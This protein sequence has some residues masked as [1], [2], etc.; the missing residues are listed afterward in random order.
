MARR[1]PNPGVDLTDA[2]GAEIK[3]PDFCRSVGLGCDECV[4]KSAVALA[5]V[6]R[7]Q[8]SIAARLFPVIYP[9]GAC[10]PMVKTF[11][12][13]YARARTPHGNSL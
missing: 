12:A 2:L 8:P 1:S 11:V 13:A 3:L 6:V 9:D 5:G 10:S 4:R 7:A